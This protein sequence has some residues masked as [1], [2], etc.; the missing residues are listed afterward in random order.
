MPPDLARLRADVERLAAIER[1]SA[2]PGERAAADWIA[3][4]L[5]G[6]GHRAR[7]ETERA[8]GSFTTPLGLLTGAAALAGLAGGRRTAALTG[9]LG[10]LG[11]LDDVSAGPHLLRR[12]LPHRD[13][14]NV[15]AE[16]G[17]PAAPR[18]LVVCAHHDAARGGLVFR[19]ELVTAI[20]D[21]FPDW[22]ARQETSAQIMCLV[23]A[24]PALV[25]LGAL[26]GVRAVR[27]A[28]TAIALG[29]VAAFADIA[30]RAVVPGANDN[31][32]AVAAL[33]ELGRALAADPPRGLRVLLLSTGSE[34][35]SMEGMRGFVARHR[36]ELDP[37]R[38][39][40]LVL[41]SIG[42]PELILL[43]GEGMIRMTDYD[44]GLRDELAAAAA[45]TG[46]PL[47]RGL[48]SGLATDALIALRAG[49]PVATLAAC[50]AYK[51]PSNYHSPLDTPERVDYGTVAAAVR[52]S[53]ALIRRR[54]G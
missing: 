16:A 45:A 5:A 25:A 12:A 1:P 51:M 20:A 47:R 31:L 19:P 2:S 42:S 36:A 6:M 30:S 4:E 41:E 10:A 50:D 37:A 38:T 7:I 22:Y 18:T 29:S 35:S 27:A 44:A 48:R 3:A 34:E 13:T 15:V 28:G 24:G 21:R 39:T 40:F 52:V 17:D 53:L 11:V 33:L 49:Y 54:S 26:T 43:E 32:S 46:E 8:V 23:A 9:A 14:F